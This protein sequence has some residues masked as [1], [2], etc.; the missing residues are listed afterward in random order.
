VLD[1]IRMANTIPDD[2]ILREEDI[3]LKQRNEDAKKILQEQSIC[4]E[5]GLKAIRC[6]LYAPP[7][8]HISLLIFAGKTR[9]AGASEDSKAED[10]I[11]PFI[12]A[13]EIGINGIHP[14]E[15]MCTLCIELLE[16]YGNNKLHLSDSEESRLQLAVTYLQIAI[17]LDIQK[18]FITS[19]ILT[20]CNDK[21]LAGPCQGELASIMNGLVNRAT[22]KPAALA[23]TKGTAVSDSNT[24]TGRDALFLL[25]SLIREADVLWQDGFEYE[26]RYDLLQALKKNYNTFT[27]QCLISPSTL[28]SN[29]G[30]PPT[31]IANGIYSLW[32]PSSSLKIKSSDNSSSPGEQVPIATG[33]L[34]DCV[35]G[36]FLCGGPQAT[37]DDTN[38]RKKSKSVSIDA[39]NVPA[40]EP[41]LRKVT[42]FRQKLN[43]I[44]NKAWQLVN[45]FDIY[46]GKILNNETQILAQKL[47]DLLLFVYQ[48]LKGIE[49]ID[50]LNDYEKPMFEVV[51][52]PGLSMIKFITPVTSSSS[53]SPSC[54]LPVAQTTATSIAQVFSI[55]KAADNVVDYNV[56]IF[57]RLIWGYS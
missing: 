2:I 28:P 12:T 50:M 30:S 53:E 10:L 56:C 6:T 43:N 5:E 32:I 21:T 37:I 22:N 26:M 47:I 11:S 35:T 25:S 19:N 27:T 8:A 51:Q 36:Y 14:W 13:F 23:S 15:T 39:S 31:V 1:D 49:D 40:Q 17:K 33:G 7:F 9:V 18:D 48:Q 20:L 34:F 16:C 42:L 54:S 44:N 29:K 55:D 24:A 4:C 52:E 38:S 46:K 57:L 41:I 45:M 3:D